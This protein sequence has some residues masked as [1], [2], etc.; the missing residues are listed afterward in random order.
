MKNINKSILGMSLL[1]LFAACSQKSPEQAASLPA[2]EVT[3]QKAM[4]GGD[5][6]YVSAT[7]QVEAS[8][9]ANLSTRMMGYVENVPV[10]TGERVKKGDLLVSVSNA[11][12][13]A[14][15][16]QAQAGVIQAEAA[17]KNAE[18]DYERFQTLF[19]KKSASQKELDD[20]T[21][22]Y[23][24]AKANLSIAREMEN[25]VNAQFSYAQIRAPFDG[26]VINKFVKEGDM[27][28]PGMPLVSIEA[29]GRMEVSALV[30]ESE[31]KYVEEGLPADIHLKSIGKKVKGTVSEVSLSSKNTGG[32]YVVKIDMDADSTVYA[33]MFAN[34]RIQT[35]SKK[36]GLSGTGVWIPES[37]L[38]HKGQL[39][40][41]YAVSNDNA[42]ILRWLRT[43]RSNGEEVEVLSGLKPEETYVVE[44]QGRLY[45][46]AKLSF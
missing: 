27:A 26:V 34:V 3:V 12:L 8:K 39:T 24:M 5:Q 46:G 36:E 21:T 43:G 2:V 37:A 7:G 23:E 14:K 42:A 1:A 20:M 31:I 6:N 4:K 16:G 9:S 17:F 18:R 13:V 29:P 28:N 33:G 44:A 38:V 15:R 19:E 35:N 25:E 40:G 41:V 10:K 11:D 32:Q 22:R 45:N 30:S